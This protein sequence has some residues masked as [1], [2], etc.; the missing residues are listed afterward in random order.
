[1]KYFVVIVLAQI[2]L[3]LSLNAFDRT[4]QVTGEAEIRVIPDEVVITVAIE[5]SNKDLIIAK[6]EN[7]TKSRQVKSIFQK[8]GVEEK[9]IKTDYITIEPRYETYPK[10]EFSG[11]FV[12]KRFV[13]T[14]KDLTK[15]ESLTTD[16]LVGG[17][18]Y[19]HD[20]TFRTTDLRKHR[21]TARQMAIK[22]AK[23]KAVA[24]ATELGMK[25]GK[26]FSI[27]EN[28][29][30]YWYNYM[31]NERQM[32]QN[33]MVELGSGSPSSDSFSP[34]MITITATVAV[35]FEME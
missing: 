22:A 34:G 3:L 24:L 32:T 21:D 23:E 15:F 25:V 28:Q 1:M 18:N 13:V 12:T 20:I 19:I 26:P 14:L 10:K 33:S 31:R 11:Y 8:S 17:V 6:Q 35:S 9:Y 27:N 5:T 29:S 2:G 4:I 30:N 7:D 16:I